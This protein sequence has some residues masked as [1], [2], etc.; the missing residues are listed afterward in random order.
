MTSMRKSAELGFTSGVSRTQPGSSFGERMPADEPQPGHAPG[1]LADRDLDRRDVGERRVAP[2][3]HRLFVW[4]AG[5]EIP[6]SML[7]VAGALALV[8]AFGLVCSAVAMVWF[9]LRGIEMAG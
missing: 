4:H 5:F 1:R 8:V 7:D 3:E 2:G 9:S 6:E